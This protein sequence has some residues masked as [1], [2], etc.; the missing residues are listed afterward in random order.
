MNNVL[1][2]C[3]ACGGKIVKKRV[4]VENWWGDNLTIVEDVPALVCESCGERYFDAETSL[5]LDQLRRKASY[6]PKRI[7][8]VP[9]YDFPNSDLLARNS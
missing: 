2:K 8:E 6:R 4:S 1:T 7:M 5:L 9:V 3:Q